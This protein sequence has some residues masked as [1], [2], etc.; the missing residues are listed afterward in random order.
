MNAV[1][2]TINRPFGWSALMITAL[3]SVRSVQTAPEPWQAAAGVVLCVAMLIAALVA[4]ERRA[5]RRQ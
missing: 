3:L 4:G 5:R 2:R 1:W